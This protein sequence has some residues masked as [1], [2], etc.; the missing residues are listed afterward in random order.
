MKDKQTIE[1]IRKATQG[2]RKALTRLCEK[3]GQ[4]IIFLCLR[5][6]GHR[7]DGY[8]AAQE[9]FIK[10]YENIGKLRDPEAFNVWL[11]RII[12]SACNDVRRKNKRQAMSVQDD[13]LNEEL[14]V[15][16]PDRMAAQLVEQEENQRL[17]MEMV[18]ALPEKYRRCVV[19]HY[20]QKLSYAEIA[21]A[22]GMNEQAVNNC[23]RMARKHLK[24]EMENRFGKAAAPDSLSAAIA[25]GPALGVVLEQTA[26]RTVPPAAVKAC[27]RQAGAY[28]LPAMGAKLA[29]TVKASIALF[30]VTFVAAASLGIYHTQT[31]QPTLPGAGF[32]QS[33]TVGAPGDVLASTLSG[34]VDLPHGED[35]EPLAVPQGMQIA[36]LAPDGQ[37]VAVAPL[38]QDRSFYF[39]D[40]QLTQTGEYTL[41]VLP[42]EDAPEIVFGDKKVT[43]TA[44]GAWL[45]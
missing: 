9:A 2:D 5:E 28:A 34:W 37:A 43:L 24:I 35:G 21:A 26:L 42:N 18:D 27:M 10:M 40:L 3:K 44:D 7:E 41:R 36:L 45:F 16:M 6:L 17:I 19:M 8:D 22:L 25:I 32:D 20:Y 4:E 12:L 14:G 23:L 15:E 39:A 38:S 31:A 29:G 13:I 11:N 30:A 1:L 33:Q